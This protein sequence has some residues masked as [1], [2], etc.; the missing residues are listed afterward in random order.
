MATKK[1]LG[2]HAILLAHRLQ[3]VDF[4]LCQKRLYVTRTQV[5]DG[6]TWGLWQRVD[7]RLCRKHTGVPASVLQY[8]RRDPPGPARLVTARPKAVLSGSS[9]HPYR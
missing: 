7:F 1:N 6:E 2:R 9:S 3:R 5:V 8:G 4:R